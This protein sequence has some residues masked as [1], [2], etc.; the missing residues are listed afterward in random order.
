MLFRSM[1]LSWYFK[2]HLINFCSLLLSCSLLLTFSLFLSLSFYTLSGLQVCDMSKCLFT[3]SY[4]VLREFPRS[5]QCMGRRVF[6][7]LV[8]A[9]CDSAIGSAVH[10]QSQYS[11][12][13]RMSVKMRKKT[14]KKDRFKGHI[15]GIKISSTI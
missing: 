1:I 9:R 13:I 4:G 12:S 14:V 7:Q 15:L 11:C 2:C 3:C 5:E 10:S 8:F 6:A